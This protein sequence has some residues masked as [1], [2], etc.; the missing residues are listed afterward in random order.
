MQELREKYLHELG[1]IACLSQ[2]I[3][4]TIFVSSS[5]RRLEN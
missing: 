1:F 4:A 5:Q 3:G 2:L